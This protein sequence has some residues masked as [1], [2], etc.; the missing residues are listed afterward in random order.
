MSA[1][2]SW[3][4]G[5]NDST[6]ALDQRGRRYSVFGPT[7]NLVPEG[8]SGINA[9]FVHYWN[10]TCTVIFDTPWQR[11][12]ECLS[13]C[14]ARGRRERRWTSIS[15]DG[16]Y[17]A[18]GPRQ[19][20]GGGRQQRC[21]RRLF[22]CDTV[23]S[24]LVSSGGGTRP[25]SPAPCAPRQRAPNES[26]GTATT[27]RSR[28]TS[29]TA[30]LLRAGSGTVVRRTWSIDSLNGPDLGDV[31]RST[32]CRRNRPVHDAGTVRDR[33]R[34]RHDPAHGGL[35]RPWSRRD[36]RGPGQ[37]RSAPPSGR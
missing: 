8:R 25:A 3:R 32:G 1:C 28:C 29:P 21:V 36:R 12:D 26:T 19:R 9:Y 27:A 30:D 33:H 22:V 15:A 5:N 16:R 6:D 14:P 10:E 34:D 11:L 4:R 20:P 17:W 31:V 13:A 18:F 7:T 2:P 24:L 23:A 37:T 35:L